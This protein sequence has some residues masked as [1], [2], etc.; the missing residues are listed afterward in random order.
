MTNRYTD[1]DCLGSVQLTAW[2]YGKSVTELT[3]SEHAYF[4]LSPSA[5]TIARRFGAWNEATEKADSQP[6]EIPSHLPFYYRAIAT[7]RRTRDLCG[8]PVTGFDYRACNH[9]IPYHDIIDEFGS[10]TQAKIESRVHTPGQT[11]YD[12]LSPPGE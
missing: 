7:L 2:A 3:R 9:E 10:W 8:H 4:G 1:S 5:S 6:Q 11:P 12:G